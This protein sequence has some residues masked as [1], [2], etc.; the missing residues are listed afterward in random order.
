VSRSLCQAIST[1]L[2][3]NDNTSFDSNFWHSFN[4]SEWTRALA[5]LDLSGLALYFWQ[6][7]KSINAE[8]ALPHYVQTQLGKSFEQNCARVA[9]TEKE[10]MNLSKLFEDGGVEHAVLKGLALVPD[11]CPDPT[12]RTQYD[13]DYLLRPDSLKRAE[14]FLQSAGYVRKNPSEDHPIVYFQPVPV[15]DPFAESLGLYSV[16]LRRPIELHL[17][18]WD[19]AEEK[20]DLRLPEDFLDRVCRRPWRDSEYPA[21]ADEDSLVFQVLHAFRHMLRNWSRLSV[22]LEISYFLKRQASDSDFWLRYRDRIRNLRWVPE[23]SVL[24]FSLA[25]KL[26]GPSVPTEIEAL[27]PSRFSALVDLWIERY[28][29]RAALANFRNDKCSLLLHGEFVD[30]RSEWAKIRRLRLFP[31]HRPHRLP[32]V[33]YKRGP[34]GVR[35]RWAGCLHAFQRFK[36]HAFSVFCY[37][38]EYPQW[39]LLRRA[40]LL[41]SFQSS[42]S[43][44]KEFGPRGAAFS[45]ASQAGGRTRRNGFDG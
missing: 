26:F 40:R 34:Q 21:L 23:A 33:L 36:F 24:V 14:D 16:G 27:V 31:M 29:Q 1:E 18:L 44:S 28:G 30:N 45:L 17:K 15:V 2:A 19:S 7:M 35:R 42:K 13:H 39:R 5:W 9:A 20:I 37:V 8:E 41:A 11:Y 4:R 6:R 3:A 22:F 25:K 32:D 10:F 38:W 12:L 43:S